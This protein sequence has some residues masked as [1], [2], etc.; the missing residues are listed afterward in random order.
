MSSRGT[1]TATEFLQPA[2]SLHHKLKPTAEVPC[3]L[4]GGAW[5]L[6][7]GGRVGGDPPTATTGWAS[8]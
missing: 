1:V 3:L 6:E 7:S 4:H 2:P 8:L 5:S